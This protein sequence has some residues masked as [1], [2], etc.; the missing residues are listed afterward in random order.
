MRKP[1][2]DVIVGG[3]PPPGALKKARPKPDN[4]AEDAADGGADDAEEQDYNPAEDSAAAF[5]EALGLKNVDGAAVLEA[6][7]TL[8]KNADQ[9]T[10]K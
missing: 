10:A 3:L 6:F 2:I 1:G 5:G 7:K 8:L 4:A 9:D